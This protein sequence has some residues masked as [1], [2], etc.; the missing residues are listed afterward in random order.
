M[1]REGYVEVP[2]GRIWYLT[3]GRQHGVPLV[4]LHGGPGF[5]H[6][7]MLPLAV[8]GEERPVVFYDQLGSGH[9]DRPQDP[10]LWRV[11]RFVEE[12]AQLR[13]ALGLE[14]VHLLGHSWGGMLL[15]SYLE[16]RPAGV[17]S[18]VFSSPCLSAERWSQ[19]Q[20]AYRAQLP[21][22]VR[23]VLDRCEREGTTDS[24]EY[25]QAMLVYY[26]RHYCRLDPWP[27]ELEWDFEHANLEVYHTMWGPA[28][29]Y[30]T[31]SLKTFD[32]TPLLPTLNVPALFT[33][34]RHD[35]ATPQTIAEFASQVPG[36]QFH[37]FEHSGHMAYLEET[38]EYV[39]VVRKFLARHE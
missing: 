24:S 33:C 25:E 10:S 39:R 7:S 38:D 26:R 15:A 12:L 14:E 30:A 8:L 9:S 32:A 17:R 2:G 28:E 6:F 16:T 34:G 18:V 36:A 23:E 1:L 27:K 3:S 19:D 5:T 4:L 31:G 21:G 29:F 20:A 13:E 37:V 35:E 22:D 11:D